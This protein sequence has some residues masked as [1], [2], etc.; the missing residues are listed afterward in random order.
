M[1]ELYLC[2]VWLYFKTYAKDYDTAYDELVT[3]CE[4]AGIEI[5][6]SRDGELR[7]EDCNTIELKCDLERN[8]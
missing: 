6:G 4:K 3:A 5:G 2:G 1:N 7:D 8:E